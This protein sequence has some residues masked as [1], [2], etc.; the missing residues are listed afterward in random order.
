MEQASIGQ[1]PFTLITRKSL[2]GFLVTLLFFV[3]F[4]SVVFTYLSFVGIIESPTTG[5]LL[6]CDLVIF[7][8]LLLLL[9][10]RIFLIFFAQ[11]KNISTSGLHM[12]LVFLFS[13]VSLIPAAFMAFFS[14]FFF[15][16]GVQ[17]WF[18]E[19]IKTAVVESNTIAESYLAEHQNTIRADILAMA[20]D[21]DRQYKVFVDNDTALKQM[22]NTQ[23]FY[24]NLSDALVFRED[25]VILVHSGSDKE[26]VLNVSDES[27]EQAKSGKVIVLNS[28]EDERVRALV[29]LK[30]FENSFLLVGRPV[31]A[32]VLSRVR[33][34]RI[35]SEKYTSLEDES[36][37]IRF[38]L[39]LMYVAL[40]IFLVFVSIWFALKIAQ[41]FI[42]PIESLIDASNRVRAGDLNIE[43]KEKTGVAELDH[44]T[45]AYNRMTIQL[46]KQRNDLVS[47]NRQLDE[48]RLFTETVLAG[49]SSGILSV[50]HEGVVKLHNAS[51]HSIL[52]G[53]EGPTL[54]GAHISEIM[55]EIEI[56]LEKILSAE[57]KSDYSFQIEIPY[58]NSNGSKKD[59][60]L[61]AV[62][63]MRGEKN[64]GAIITFDDITNLKSAQR[65][66]AWSDVARRI[67]HEIKN[68]LTPIQL[69][70]ERIRKKFSKNIP[71][72]E[73]ETFE[74]C[75]ETISRHV[76]DIGAMVSEFSSFARMPEAKIRKTD[77]STLIKQCVVFHQE[78]HP[79]IKIKLQGLLEN[80]KKISLHCDEQL[81]RQA[82]VNILQNALDAVTLKEE[83]KIKEISVWLH[84]REDDLCLIV[85]DSG[86][87]FMMDENVEKLLDP[88]VT[89]KKNGTGLGLAI[90]KKIMADHSGEI[91]LGALPWMSE[92]KGWRE[93]D[94]A[95]VSLIFPSLYTKN[96]KNKD[97]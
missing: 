12:K 55:P 42:R 92:I 63:E 37:Q 67:A 62:P 19:Q 24:R 90:V 96:G 93:M 73:R 45:K 61:R 60:L 54:M 38:T 56:S 69:S 3:G 68:P 14:I 80:K 58:L 53:K 16:Y 65:S 71:E 11:K 31:D 44:L 85:Q 57:S 89:H 84:K 39:I 26:G 5:Q 46:S 64:I 78:G 28:H 40:S 27:L 87:G 66:A 72:K 74:T 15:H 43:L 82:F 81:V 2:D 75:I 34:T 88:Y 59:L 18:S 9:G 20:N 49:V 22:I 17:T 30:A 29:K 33:R 23:A 52:K 47:A 48:R 8:C 35:A 25:G 1:N 70:A 7:V 94:G 21:L 77:I 6:K 79:D 50:D 86:E 83:T 4:V 76:E 95:V 97:A 41:K 10:R 32:T 36:T 91:T 13:F 51:A